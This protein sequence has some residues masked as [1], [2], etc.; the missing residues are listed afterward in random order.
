MATSNRSSLCQL[1]HSRDTEF[2]RTLTQRV[3]Q[4]NE[5]DRADSSVAGLI[6]LFQVSSTSRHGRIGRSDNAKNQ[7]TNLFLKAESECSFFSLESCDMLKKKKEEA[8]LGLL[9]DVY[10]FFLSLRTMF[11]FELCLSLS[12]TFFL[13]IVFS[14]KKKLNVF[15]FGA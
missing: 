1:T 8:G 7:I 14:K 5:S 12:N 15:F 3:R 11:S 9:A 10:G 4:L 13:T 6:I 2:N